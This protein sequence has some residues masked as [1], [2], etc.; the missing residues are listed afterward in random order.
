MLADINNIKYLQNI[1]KFHIV[2]EYSKLPIETFNTED[3]AQD[4]IRG[5]RSGLELTE[6]MRLGKYYRMCVEFDM[7]DGVQYRKVNDLGVLLFDPPVGG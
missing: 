4:F 1:N 3:E 2:V 7:K 6:V 5:Y